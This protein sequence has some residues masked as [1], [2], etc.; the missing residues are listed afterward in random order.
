[1]IEGGSDEYSKS[2][3]NRTLCLGDT[4]AVTHLYFVFIIGKVS[5]FRGSKRTDGMVVMANSILW[6]Q[7]HEA[8]STYV[9]SD[10]QNR[11]WSVNVIITRVINCTCAHLTQGVKTQQKCVQRV[12]NVGIYWSHSLR[13]YLACEERIHR[14]YE[15]QPHHIFDPSCTIS[16]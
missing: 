4:W 3:K 12:E 10:G 11:L 5:V 15:V 14:S 8:E 1:M 7:G 9:G 16:H 2:M 13:K 6:H